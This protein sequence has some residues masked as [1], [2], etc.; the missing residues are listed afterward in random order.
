MPPRA[1][2]K[3]HLKL[4]LVSIPVCL[5]NAIS[6][7]SRV[8][9]NQLHK[10]CNR[11]LKQQMVCPEHGNVDRAEIDVPAPHEV[12]Q[13]HD[14]AARAGAAD[15]FSETSHCA[16]FLEALCFEYRSMEP[17]MTP[18]RIAPMEPPYPPEM[19]A[20]FDRVMAGKPPLTLFRIVA[21]NPRV[22]SRL[23]GG[24]L[25]DKG[26]ITLRQDYRVT[27]PPGDYAMQCVLFDPGPGAGLSVSN[28][29]QV[30]VD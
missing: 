21:R 18:P 11:R 16:T 26:S 9:M 1:S 23:F 24:G 14:R 25:L 30:H 29:V 19:Q 4:S 7:A 13:H 27:P 10:D 3:G 5:Y 17:P 20:A 22:L 8:S 2:W 28:M 15:G 12:Q 6:S